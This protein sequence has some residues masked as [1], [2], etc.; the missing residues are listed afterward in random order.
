MSKEAGITPRGHR[1][2][3]LPDQIEEFSKGGIIVATA[4]Q[5]DR[6]Q[7]GQTDGIVVALGN[8]AYE[9]LSEPWC[10]VGDKVLIAKYAGMMR[11]GLDSKWYRIIS[12]TDI[13]AILD[14]DTDND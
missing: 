4:S 7:L 2:L 12:D 14:K 13:V 9:D 3:I 10:A 5:L 6:E 1:I 8:T 11:Q